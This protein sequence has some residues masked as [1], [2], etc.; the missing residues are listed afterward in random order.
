MFAI[1]IILLVLELAIGTEGLALHRLLYAWPSFLAYVVSFAT[2]GAA[3]LAHDALT[4]RLTK[5]NV[6]L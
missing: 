3:W 1:A 4:D 6:G 5:T 2:I